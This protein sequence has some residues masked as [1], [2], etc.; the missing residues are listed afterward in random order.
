TQHDVRTPAQSRQLA[1]IVQDVMLELFDAP[2]GDRYQIIETLP[3]GS[4]LAEDT[5][6]GIERSDGVVI[7]HVTQQ[8]RSTAQKQAIYSALAE[9]LA[10]ADLV[11]PEDLIVSVVHNDREDWSC[12]LG[13]AQCVTGALC[14]G[15]RAGGSNAHRRR[16]TA[17][18]PPTNHHR[19]MS[20]QRTGPVGS[21]E[22]P[23][24]RR[25][26]PH[27]AAAAYGTDADAGRHG[28][29]WQQTSTSSLSAAAVWTSTRWRSR[30]ASRTST[31]SASSS[32]AA[33]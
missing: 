25:A 20:A 33:R 14:R 18:A 10:A 31:A 30:R 17:L 21:W 5:G 13:R 6:L 23:P 24:D 2:P 28:D 1:D 32:A 27:T 4:I 29:P 9:R 3:V 11:R 7:I 22:H 16:G 12:G 26:P 19:Y 8:G 15:G